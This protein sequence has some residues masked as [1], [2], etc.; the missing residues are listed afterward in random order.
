M[1]A[2]PEGGHNLTEDWVYI[3][4]KDLVTGEPLF[5]LSYFHNRRDRTAKR[6]A[7]MK[8]MLLFSARPFFSFYLNLLRTALVHH[9]DSGD[10]TV[11]KEL[12]TR[13]NDLHANHCTEDTLR[14]WGANIPVE[15]TR[16]ARSN[17]RGGSWTP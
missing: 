13:V 14:L 9:L 16:G 17:P 7:I 2:V 11:L 4:K 12:V 8:A 15:V 1:R 6:G 3:V 5:G 10:T